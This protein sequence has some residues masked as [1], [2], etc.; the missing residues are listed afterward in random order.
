M[1]SK[2]LKWLNEIEGDWKITVIIGIGHNNP[3]EVR[4]LAMDNS[5]KVEVITDTAIISRYMAAADI[6]IT[7][8]GRTVFELASLG[9]PMLVIAQNERETHHIFANSSP[10]LVYLGLASMLKKEVFFDALSQ[11]LGSNLL[12]EKMHDILLA[13]GIHQGINHV[14]DTIE[15]ALRIR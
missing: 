9:V 6:V 15:S 2:C 13:S 3:N 5:H 7:S 11:L 1:T 10:G 12:R 4:Q 14:I 8:G